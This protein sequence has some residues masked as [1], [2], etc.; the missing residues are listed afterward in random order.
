M[1]QNTARKYT[2]VHGRDQSKP[3]V[4]PS[5]PRPLTSRRLMLLS[6]RVRGSCCSLRRI[7]WHPFTATTAGW[8]VLVLMLSGGLWVAI[9]GGAG[10]AVAETCRRFHRCRFR[11]TLIASHERVEQNFFFFRQRKNF[12]WR[13]N[14]NDGSVMTCGFAYQRIEDT[15]GMQSAYR[16]VQ[17]WYPNFP[18]KLMSS[19]TMSLLLIPG[20]DFYTQECHGRLF[21][22]GIPAV[23][24]PDPRVPRIKFC[25]RQISW[26]LTFYTSEVET[27]SCWSSRSSRSR[28][29]KCP[30]CWSSRFWILIFL[31][32][33]S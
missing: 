9:G 21:K 32:L 17:Y 20:V 13:L 7:C 5:R 1:A 30:S 25:C 31:I 10:S 24:N 27:A 28:R 22:M 11:S 19:C 3:H 29:K 2:H 26:S 12:S 4:Q 8:D 15:C 23:P 18:K 33:F 16:G 14:S 6:V